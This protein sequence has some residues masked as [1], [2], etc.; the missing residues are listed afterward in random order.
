MKILQQNVQGF[1]SNR[2]S[3]EIYVNNHNIDVCLFS[4]IFGLD[5]SDPDCRLLNYNVFSK[6]RDDRYGGCA[7]CIK[8]SIVAR[9]VA[10]ASSLD[11]IIVKT[12][13]LNPNIV[14]VS[15]YF[16]PSLSTHICANEVLR[17]LSFLDGMPN[18]II[19]GDFNARHSCWG[20]SFDSP[21]G[22]KL[23]E[24]LSLSDFVCLNDGSITFIPHLD[25]NNGSVL[26]LTFARLTLPQL[27]WQTGPRWCGGSHHFPIILEIGSVA[28]ARL[29]FLSKK[30]LLNNLSKL[31]I[32][33]DANL[34][35]DSF[36]S[37]IAN[38]TFK[39]G[40]FVP[41]AWWNNTLLALFRKHIAFR[42]KAQKYPSQENL[43]QSL[44]ATENWKI[45]VKN[46]KRENYARRIQELNCQPNTAA[47]W[48]FVNSLK[49]VKHNYP[50]FWDNSKNGSFLSYLAGQVPLNVQTVFPKLTTQVP[51][52]FTYDDLIC[53][54]ESKRRSTAGGLDRVTY[55]MVKSLPVSSKKSLL[56]VFNDLFTKCLIHDPWRRIRIVP[57]PKRSS[58]FGDFRDY[59]PI[60]LISVFLKLINMM[61]KSRLIDATDR[62]NVLPKRCF[63]YRGKM[64]T[65]TCLNELLFRVSYLKSSGLRVVV[66]SIDISNAY[67][68]VN[69]STLRNIMVSQGIPFE[70]IDWISNFLSDRTLCM[71][72]SSVR[73]FNG[74]PQGS[75]LSPCLFNLYTTKFHTLEDD[76]TLVFQYADDFLIV[77]SGLMF[78]Q[79]VSNLRHKIYQFQSI[80]TSLNLLFNPSK[81][82]CMFF[83]RRMNFDMNLMID[84]HS[85]LQV[86]SLKF[87]GFNIKNTLSVNDHYTRVLRESSSA[88]NLLKRLT[89]IRGGLGPQASLNFYRS[90]I[91]S[92]IEYARSVSAHAPMYIDRKIQTFQNSNLRRC[93]GLCPSTPV[94]AIYVLA[95]EYPPSL[96]SVYLASKEL[97]KIACYNPGLMDLIRSSPDHLCNSYSFVYRKF[98][99]IFDSIMTLGNVTT[100]PKL[101]V[102]IES[103]FNK[104]IGFS[105]EALNAHY[106]SLVDSYTNMNFVLVATDASISEAGTGCAVFNLRTGRFFLNKIPFKLSSLSGE[107]IAIK[108]AVDTAAEDNVSHLVIFTDSR[109]ACV[110]LRR[111]NSRNYLIAEILSLI[112]H[113]NLQV[114]HIIWVPAHVGVSFN[115][116]VDFL[117]KQAVSLGAPLNQA[118]PVDDAMIKIKNILNR[119]WLESYKSRSQ[120]SGRFFF[121]L[122]PNIPIKPWYR[123]IKWDA[124]DIKIVNR[125]LCG[126]CYSGVYLH[127]IHKKTSDLC[128][129]CN[130]L[131]NSEHLIFRCAEF[132]EIRSRHRFFLSFNNLFDILNTHNIGIYHQLISFIKEAMIQNRL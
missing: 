80:S 119:E 15:V 124:V 110:L 129:F 19:G 47:A 79:A 105:K 83:G 40:K 74:L 20:D 21:R 58:T 38:A 59:R 50:S 61:V 111:A 122:F 57:I 29:K 108:R 91:R 100:T 18:V 126:H 49:S 69:V 43:E 60:A 125:L 3:I 31:E 39:S 114:V 25:R 95:N 81:T 53:A 14:F 54:L 22:C 56:Y 26:D 41:K 65:S 51:T 104:K 102:F 96:R 24:I 45:A 10:F 68:C 112:S 132:C 62:L 116:K 90:F 75:C 99:D 120:V 106:R 34:I 11:I 5:E 17:L 48:R 64:S 28:V 123:N 127:M 92:K 9:R 130:M 23:S 107:L 66:A 121:S 63:A 13:N 4:E 46:A 7:I 33:R 52:F 44:T 73:V 128:D 101:K 35:V 42:S 30:R 88:T 78:D 85:I 6:V 115:E 93:L 77:S 89:S 71:G 1:R 87:L 16:P 70:L 12:I 67:D 36:G 118:L 131:D 86:N 32:E 94:Q 2:P 8:K 72:D 117:A 27:N 84:N 55:E 103:S 109:N 113:S 37:A 98:K 97:L 82:K 76:N